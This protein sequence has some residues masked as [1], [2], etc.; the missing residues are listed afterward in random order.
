MVVDFDA[1]GTFLRRGQFRAKAVQDFARQGCFAGPAF[2][3]DEQFGFFDFFIALFA[4]P[5]I[6]EDGGIALFYNFH[7]RVGQGFI[8]VQ[9]Q[10]LQLS[11]SGRQVK[12]LQFIPAQIQIPQVFHRCRHR[13]LGQ[14]VV[15]QVER[16]YPGRIEAG[17]IANALPLIVRQLC[18]CKV[19]ARQNTIL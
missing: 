17:Q 12:L 19:Q 9:P 10:M 7:R 8:P 5:E 4:L 16:C 11:A 2:A 15:P 13:R 3:Q 14:L 6:I 18:A 1:V